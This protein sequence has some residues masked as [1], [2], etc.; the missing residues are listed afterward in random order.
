MKSI[1]LAV[2]CAILVATGVTYASE[3]TEFPLA[4]STQVSRAEVRALAKA[5]NQAGQMRYDF[6]G[7]TVEPMS[8][9]TR[10]EVR[11]EALE[12][13]GRDELRDAYFVGGM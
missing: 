9:K 6:V 10:E 12:H 5:A 4:D 11:K 3:I 13:K 7:P 1:Q 2:A 8:H